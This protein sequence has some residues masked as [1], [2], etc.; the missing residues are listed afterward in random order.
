M[1]QP[2]AH[3]NIDDDIVTGVTLVVSRTGIRP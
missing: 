3:I 2:E 1:R